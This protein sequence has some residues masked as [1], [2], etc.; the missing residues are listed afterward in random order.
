MTT[1]DTPRKPGR[2]KGSKNVKTNMY[3]GKRVTKNTEKRLEENKV[4]RE[5]AKEIVELIKSR[6][7]DKTEPEKVLSVTPASMPRDMYQ[8][9]SFGAGM[10]KFHTRL[11]TSKFETKGPPPR[12]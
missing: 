10:R 6:S 11:G 5:Q 4:K 1:P 2:P 9:D 3:R 7:E 8:V 12:G